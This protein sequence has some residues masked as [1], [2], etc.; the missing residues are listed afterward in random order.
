MHLPERYDAAKRICPWSQVEWREIWQLEKGGKIMAKWS[1][2][3]AAVSRLSWY[4]GASRPKLFM[5]GSPQRLTIRDPRSAPCCR[6]LLWATRPA[7]WCKSSHLSLIALSSQEAPRNQCASVQGVE[8]KRAKKAQRFLAFAHQAMFHFHG[9]LP[10]P[11]ACIV[12][13]PPR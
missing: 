9:Y 3:T 5:V 8:T 10:P 1:S 12:L 7:Q 11:Q 13:S 4:F 2:K 6:G